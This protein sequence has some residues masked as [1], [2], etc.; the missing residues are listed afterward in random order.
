MFKIIHFINKK[1]IIIMENY[2]HFN[3]SFRRY[4]FTILKAIHFYALR[5]F[6]EPFLYELQ[7]QYF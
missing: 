5:Y 6:L 4:V 1:I 3:P 7:T 2:R